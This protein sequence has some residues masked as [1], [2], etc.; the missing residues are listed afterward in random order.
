MA[1]QIHE[2]GRVGALF[3]SKA[4]VQLIINPIVG[5]VTETRGYTTPLVCG[6]ATLFLSALST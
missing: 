5:T 6:T 1:L 4:F 2:N 3:A